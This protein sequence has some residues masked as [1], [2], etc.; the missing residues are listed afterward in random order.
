M[1]S[2]TNR[3]RIASLTDAHS[4]K[5]Q[6]MAPSPAASIHNPVDADA[7]LQEGA[8]I[9]ADDENS[10]FGEGSVSYVTLTVPENNN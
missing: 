3:D 9:E 1:A 8:E 4:H 7:L 6:L 5:E 10:A 2:T